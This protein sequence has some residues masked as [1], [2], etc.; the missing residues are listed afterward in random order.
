MLEEISI[1]FYKTHWSKKTEQIF[2]QI[3]SAN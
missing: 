3:V 1:M 2:G